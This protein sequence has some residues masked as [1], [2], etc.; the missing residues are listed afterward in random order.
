MASLMSSASRAATT[1]LDLVSS[2]VTTAS[3]LV[4]QL[5]RTVDM[6]DQKT[7]TLHRAVINGS[8]MDRAGD[9]IAQLSEKVAD[10]VARMEAIHQRSKRVTPF[11]AA[12]CERE[13][14]SAFTAAL[15][16]YHTEP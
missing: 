15:T 16:A 1:T 13:A 11:D 5:S 2:T 3:Q 9:D 10:H 8:V 14:L 6:L 4:N 7:Q 12:S